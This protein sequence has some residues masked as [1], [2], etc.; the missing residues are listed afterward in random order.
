MVR[1]GLIEVTFEHKLLGGE[2]EGHEIIEGKNILSKGASLAKTLRRE[3]TGGGCRNTAGSHMPRMEKMSPDGSW[4]VQS[5]WSFE[6]R[7]QD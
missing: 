7:C 6:G 5:T 2:G 3:W 1:G 4:V